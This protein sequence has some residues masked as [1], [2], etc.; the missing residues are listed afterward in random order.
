MLLVVTGREGQVAWS[1]AERAS[2]SDVQ[3][4]TL[5]RL[6]LDL[7]GPAEAIIAAIQA[8]R[9]DVIV[10]GAAYTQ[11]DKAEREPELAFCV[12]ESGALAVAQAASRVGVP[13]IQFPTA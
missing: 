5:A 6:E 10:S 11:V 9:P 12:N 13:S 8:A 1:L 2:A 4:I 3:L 7:A